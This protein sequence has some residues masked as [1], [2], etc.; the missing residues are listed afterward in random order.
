MKKLLSMLLSVVLLL[1]VLAIISVWLGVRPR[2][3]EYL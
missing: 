1:S 3:Q 2:L